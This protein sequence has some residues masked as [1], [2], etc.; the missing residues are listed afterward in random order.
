MI[1]YEF[2]STFPA[3]KRA[4]FNRAVKHWNDNSSVRLYPRRAAPAGGV[5]PDKDYVLVQN[6]LDA[7]GKETGCWA[8]LGKRGGVQE[9]NLGA[10]CFYHQYIHEIGHTLGLV[11]EQNRIDR[12]DFVIF[13]KDNVKVDP[14]TGKDYSAQFEKSP[15][16]NLPLEFDFGS[17]MLYAS[18]AFAVADNKYTLT[19]PDGSHWDA[20]TK[21]MS[22]GDFET[23]GEIYGYRTPPREKRFKIKSGAN[24]ITPSRRNP[25]QA[26]NH[27]PASP[28]NDT[29]LLGGVCSALPEPITVEKWRLRGDGSIRGYAGKCVDTKGGLS[30][31]GTPVIMKTCPDTGPLA[32]QKWTVGADGSLRGI[33]GKCL[34]SSGSA[35]VRAL[36]VN[37]CALPL[38]AAQKWELVEMPPRIASQPPA[39]N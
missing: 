8:R 32:S 30:A 5:S 24:C 15:V 38:P 26:V 34:T 10:G 4:E 19:K 29:E 12:D 39:P 7:K 25:T 20:Q 6:K 11:H 28:F 37:K 17:R 9:I 21:S 27:S 2:D 1:P 31:D 14:S 35:S 23:V 22:P 16:A 33:E 36:S 18:N 3:S 13:N